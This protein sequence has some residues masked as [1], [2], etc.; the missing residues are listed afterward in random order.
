MSSDDTDQ[1]HLLILNADMGCPWHFLNLFIFCWGGLVDTNE[2]KL[3]RIK[4]IQC[5]PGITH[6]NQ[7]QCC[8]FKEIYL[9]TY[10]VWHEDNLPDCR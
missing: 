5:Q 6:S 4:Q 2:L 1:T 8:S 3:S 9:A 7:S 10:R